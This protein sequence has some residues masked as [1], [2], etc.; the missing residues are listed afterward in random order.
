MPCGGA[1]NEQ[2][3]K[4]TNQVKMRVATQKVSSQLGPGTTWAQ[5][6]N[7]WWGSVTLRVKG[8]AVPRDV[9][10]VRSRITQDEVKSGVNLWRTGKERLKD[11]ILRVSVAPLWMQTLPE[12]T[13]KESHLCP[14]SS[15]A[16]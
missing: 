12:D 13:V 16:S 3:L 6:G 10:R 1:V 2:L 11:P 5:R 9:T 15:P 14:Q 4:G 8:K 7:M